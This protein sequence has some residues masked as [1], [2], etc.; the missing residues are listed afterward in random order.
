MTSHFLLAFYT[1][2]DTYYPGHGSVCKSLTQGF[3]KWLSPAFLLHLK[4]YTI[5]FTDVTLAIDDTIWR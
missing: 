2:P 4:L 5:K 3:L 1:Y